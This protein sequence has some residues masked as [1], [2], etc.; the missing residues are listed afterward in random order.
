MDKEIRVKKKNIFRFRGLDVSYDY[1][2]RDNDT[3]IFQ[4]GD[5]ELK[6]ENGDSYFIHFEYHL[7]DDE[8]VIT[9]WWENDNAPIGFEGSEKY[10]NEGE[11]EWIKSFAS[12]FINN[13]EIS[14]LQKKDGMRYYF[15]CCCCGTTNKKMDLKK[16]IFGTNANGYVTEIIMCKRCREKLRV[17]LSEDG[18]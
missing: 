9:I 13:I 14:D 8:W 6:E 16:I 4:F 5:G 17:V 18:K 11:V 10:I 12:K 7:S 2:W 3:F 1:C 15:E